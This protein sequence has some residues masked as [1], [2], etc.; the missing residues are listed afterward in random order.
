ML[1]FLSVIFLVLQIIAGVFAV[2]QGR[3]TFSGELQ[4]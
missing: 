2:M 3:L 4:L 1:V